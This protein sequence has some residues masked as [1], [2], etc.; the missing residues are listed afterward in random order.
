M[1]AGGLESMGLS[2]ALLDT[3]GL[4]ELYYNS[5]NPEVGETQP[6]QEIDKLNIESKLT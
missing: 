6:L 5:Y 3:Q 2:V 4:I 1:I